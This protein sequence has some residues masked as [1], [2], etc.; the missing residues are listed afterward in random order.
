MII[1]R[2]LDELQHI[3]FNDICYYIK[4][5]TGSPYVMSQSGTI[6][7]DMT[8]I[9]SCKILISAVSSFAF[10]PSYLGMTNEVHIPVFGQNKI[11]KFD[12]YKNPTYKTYL[13]KTSLKKKIT[14][15]TY[16]R[17]YT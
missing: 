11:Y 3:I 17:M 16:L 1:G 2:P 4:T 14:K 10:W 9:M 8:A 6:S 13:Y 12:K 7:E 5:L 15:D